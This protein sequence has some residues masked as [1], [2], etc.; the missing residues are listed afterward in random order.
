[1]WYKLNIKVLFWIESDLILMLWG[2]IKSYKL[3]ENLSK[4][5]FVHL[6]AGR[7]VS[8]LH[9]S[10]T[11]CYINEVHSFQTSIALVL[12]LMGIFFSQPNHQNETVQLSHFFRKF[13]D[14]PRNS[15]CSKKFR[16]IIEA[17]VLNK[18]V[19]VLT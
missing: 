6:S 11:F 3:D 14:F 8:Q 16:F 19:E 17:E 10:P 2:R 1:M 13:I 7:S 5:T 15:N 18:V 4:C 12:I 9:I